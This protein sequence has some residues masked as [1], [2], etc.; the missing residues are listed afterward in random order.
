MQSTVNRTQTRILL[1]F[2]SLRYFPIGVIAPNSLF[3][4]YFTG[5]LLQVNHL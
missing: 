4:E 3:P 2:N 1:I 5:N